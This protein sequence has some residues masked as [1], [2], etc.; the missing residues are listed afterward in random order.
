MYYITPKNLKEE[1]RIVHETVR[2]AVSDLGGDIKYLNNKL[3]DFDERIKVL[4]EQLS[5]LAEELKNDWS[6]RIN[7]NI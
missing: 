1:I 4:E 5:M 6:Q 7:R 2:I 3:T